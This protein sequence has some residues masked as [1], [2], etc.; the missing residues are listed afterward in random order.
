LCLA[1]LAGPG[2]AADWPQWRGPDRSGVSRETGLLKAWPKKGP[3]L[4]WTYREA[5]I[6]FSGPAVVGDRLYTLGA[7][8]DTEYVI[9]L[10]VKTGQEVWHTKVGPIY[11]FPGNSYGDG[12]RS[13][14]TV[15]GDVLY[16]LG[17]LGDLVC[18]ACKDGKERWRKN[19][20]KDLGGSLAA[21][22]G[23][24]KGIG[25]GYS[26]GPLVDGDQLICSPG[27]KQ[28]TLAAL[29]KQ[30]GKVKW[31]SKSLPDDATYVSLVAAEIGGVRQY[32][33]E[34]YRGEQ[35]GGAVVGV[36]AKDGAL[37]WTFPQPR[38]NV[39]AIVPTPIVHENAVYVSVGYGAGCDLLQVSP[40]GKGKFRVKQLYKTASRRN[41]KNE[42]GG[43]VRVDGHVYGYSDKI[44]WVC[45]ELTTGKIAWK[46]KQKLVR[47]S[48]IGADGHL[49]LF[50]DEGTAVLI[51]ASP[52][53]WKEGG[54]FDLP[55]QSKLK[56]TR[57][58]NSRAKIWTPPVVA[59]GRLY[60]RDQELL[61]CYD[62]AEKK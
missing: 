57:K 18:V 29:D 10:D 20:L 9:A 52:K 8:G 21:T 59:N 43:V 12:P 5:G 22:A 44:G 25:W 3:K 28:G 37:L 54:R 40:A 61:F 33:A 51:E 41:M 6:G 11:T 15:D 32:V 42:F 60:L 30:T 34:T 35:E 36:A 58:G 4:L 13:T 26:E 7:R 23:S 24:P 49:Y 47:G 19:L 53:G 45:Q 31:R 17:G 38:W 2:R 16:A 62:V 55:E 27:G 48:L 50:S 56:G 46:N 39:T 1:F 14:P